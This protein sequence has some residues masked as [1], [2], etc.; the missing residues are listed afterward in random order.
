[1]EDLNL[2]NNLE[3]FFDFI[4]QDK[5]LG[6]GCFLAVDNQKTPF[7]IFKLQTPLSNRFYPYNI[8]PNFSKPTT[9]TKYIAYYL[10]ENDNKIEK[11]RIH[12]ATF[13]AP[14]EV[15]NTARLVNICLQN[16][17]A[18]HKGVGSTILKLAQDDLVQQNLTNLEARFFPF[19]KFR[20]DVASL[21]FY[22]KL[23][24]KFP[25][26]CGVGE[27]LSKPLDNI[28][29]KKRII[30]TNTPQFVFLDPAPSP[31]QTLNK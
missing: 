28:Y 12:S 5:V 21:K 18:A 13:I 29:F 1:M 23:G 14:Y 24:F 31:K 11:L 16:E 6:Q 20:N 2:V 4:K 22:D 17:I 19:S 25:V 30:D 9:Q 27:I 8:K 3:T 26:K 15:E 10:T 7:A